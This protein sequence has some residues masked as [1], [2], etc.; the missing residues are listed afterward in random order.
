MQKEEARL[1]G[2]Q[3]VKVFRPDCLNTRRWICMDERRIY[4][5][6]AAPDGKIDRLIFGKENVYGK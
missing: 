2:F 5:N 1:K 4:V 6:I 3:R